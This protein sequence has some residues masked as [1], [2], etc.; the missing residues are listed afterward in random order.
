LLHHL[1]QFQAYKKDGGASYGFYPMQDIFK[2]AFGDKHGLQLMADL[3]EMS[4]RNGDFVLSEGIKIGDDGKAKFNSLTGQAEGM[5]VDLSKLDADGINTISRFTVRQESYDKDGQ[6]LK[7]MPLQPGYKKFLSEK[8]LSE[9]AVG[10]LNRKMSAKTQEAIVGSYKELNN[11]AGV[12]AK[13]N[14]DMARSI[15]EQFNNAAKNLKSNLRIDIPELKVDA[16]VSSSGA[17]EIEL[18]VGSGE[19]IQLDK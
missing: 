8:G 10:R 12:V 16:K 13:T 1:S 3:G 14:K 4:K 15:Q 17:R 9:D 5:A 19:E 6:P 18:D 7:E 11:M 2:K